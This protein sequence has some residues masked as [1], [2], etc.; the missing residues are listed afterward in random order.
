MNRPSLIST[1]VLVVALS[2]ALTAKAEP[3]PA[4]LPSTEPTAA[5]A[6]DPAAT[7][8]LLKAAG[9]VYNSIC[10]AVEKGDIDTARQLSEDLLKQ[11]D[12]FRE[13]VRGTPLLLPVNMGITQLQHLHDALAAKDLEK[14]KT[15]IE[16]LDQ[17]GSSIARAVEALQPAPST[18][19]SDRR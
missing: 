4:T 6:F 12:D 11:S 19:R 9:G 8:T 2:V 1:A 16:G 13:S 5:A 15:I 17:I 7:M 10:D 3:S 18:R 14:A